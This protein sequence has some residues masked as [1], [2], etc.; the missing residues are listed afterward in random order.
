MSQ[1]SF[2]MIPPAGPCI[3]CLKPTKTMRKNYP[4]MDL[5]TFYCK[6]CQQIRKEQGH[7]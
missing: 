5:V 7:V 4:A 3:S 1:H 6:R 2:E